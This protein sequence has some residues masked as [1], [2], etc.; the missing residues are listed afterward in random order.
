[1]LVGGLSAELPRT[2]DGSSNE[3]ALSEMKRYVEQTRICVL[4]EGSFGNVLHVFTLLEVFNLACRPGCR[5]RVSGRDNREPKKPGWM[6]VGGLSADVGCPRPRRF[7]REDLLSFGFG[8][9]EAEGGSESGPF[10]RH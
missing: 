10:D 2:A 5:T 1:M 4:M 8:F 9:L 6:L 3:R 7:F